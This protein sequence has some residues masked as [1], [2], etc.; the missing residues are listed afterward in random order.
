MLEFY[1]VALTKQMP[2]SLTGLD[3]SKDNQTHAPHLWEYYNQS[4]TPSR[5]D[6]STILPKSPSSSGL[7]LQS[8][9]P[10]PN[11]TPSNIPS[12]LSSSSDSQTKRSLR[13]IKLQ[14]LKPSEIKPTSPTQQSFCLESTKSSGK[15]SQKGILDFSSKN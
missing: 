11:T 1:Q 12:K 13:H 15:S 4:K 14:L 9:L 6:Y 10:S 3:I 7:H 8:S 5:E 2:I